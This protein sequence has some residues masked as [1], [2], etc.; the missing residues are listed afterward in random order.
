MD[1]RVFT[2]NSV[3][4]HKMIR[5]LAEKIANYK[6]GADYWY[7]KYIGVN[8]DDVDNLS[9]QQLYMNWFQHMNKISAL[10]DIIDQL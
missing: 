2:T 9:K 7:D 10:Q 8:A 4:R 6:N 1:E 3:E 5:L